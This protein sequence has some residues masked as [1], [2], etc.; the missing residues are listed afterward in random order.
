MKRTKRQKE[1][2]KQ[3]WLAAREIRKRKR[4]EEE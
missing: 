1:F 4:E 3:F 2:Q